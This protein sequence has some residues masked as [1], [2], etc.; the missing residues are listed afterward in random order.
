[1]LTLIRFPFGLKK[2]EKLVR[3]E[4][5]REIEKAKGLEEIKEIEVVKKFREDE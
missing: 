1:M 5:V 2:L 4:E 3:F